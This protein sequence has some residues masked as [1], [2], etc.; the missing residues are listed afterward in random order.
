L[1]HH[2]DTVWFVVLVPLVRFALADQHRCGNSSENDHDYN[3]NE[4]RATTAAAAATAL[5]STPAL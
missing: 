5:S 1:P 4:D 3:N 2:D